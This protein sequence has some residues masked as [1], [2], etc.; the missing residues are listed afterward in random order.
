MRESCSCGD[1]RSGHAFDQ[2]KN[3]RLAIRV[4]KGADNGENHGSFPLGSMFILAVLDMSFLDWLGNFFVGNRLAKVIIRAVPR[5]GP[6]P[7]SKSRNFAQRMKLPQRQ[8]KNFLNEIIHF[9]GWNSSEQNAVDHARVA[10]VEASE[11]STIAGASGA[12]ESVV[13]AWFGDRPASHSLTFHACGPKV[14]AVSHVQAIET[15]GYY[16]N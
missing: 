7:S 15:T 14:N 16:G 4:R 8:Q 3:E 5:D 9:A 13:L 10:V 6:Q 1:F 12:N 2:P 11:S